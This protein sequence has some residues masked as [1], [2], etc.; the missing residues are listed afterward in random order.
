VKGKNEPVAIFEP[1]GKPADVDRAVLDE[2]AAWDAALAR[3]RAQ[4]WDVAASAIAALHAAHPQRALYAL[5]LERIAR[6]RAEP[7]GAGWDGVTTFDTK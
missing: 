2:L 5:Y 4:D 7:P 3:V 6:W 1:L